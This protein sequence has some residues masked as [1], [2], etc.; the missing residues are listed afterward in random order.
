MK[1]TTINGFDLAI[2]EVNKNALHVT[3]RRGFINLNIKEFNQ[4]TEVKLAA[5]NHFSKTYHRLPEQWIEKVIK[6]PADTNK[7]V[8]I[9][10]IK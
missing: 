6:C 5:Y 8:L 2:F 1:T 7:R 10:I 3:V 9:L 4:Q